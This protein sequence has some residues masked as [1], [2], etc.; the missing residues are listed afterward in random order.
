MVIYI[1]AKAQLILFLFSKEKNN[2][3]NLKIII[4]N[5]ILFKMKSQINLNFLTC[6]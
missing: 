3:N 2:N 5:N 4:I 1:F 6:K